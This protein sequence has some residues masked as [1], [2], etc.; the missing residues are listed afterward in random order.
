[1]FQK[2]DQSYII[3]GNK[4]NRVNTLIFLQALQFYQFYDSAMT[5]FNIKVVNSNSFLLTI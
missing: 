4:E 2:Y 1:M 3:E 5:H